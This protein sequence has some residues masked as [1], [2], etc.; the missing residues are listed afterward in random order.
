MAPY[1]DKEATKDEVSDVDHCHCEIGVKKCL[2]T[3]GQNFVDTTRGYCKT[4]LILY[5]YRIIKYLFYIKYLSAWWSWTLTINI[6]CIKAVKPNKEQ[7]NYSAN[8][9]TK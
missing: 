5:M 2:N 1:T 8:Y 4:Y 7:S 6:Q 9:I 3:S